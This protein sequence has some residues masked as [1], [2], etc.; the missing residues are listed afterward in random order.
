MEAGTTEN[1]FRF[2][3]E[4]G[5]KK[6]GSIWEGA[7]GQG[8]GSV[9]L[10]AGEQRARLSAN[11]T[12]PVVCLRTAYSTGTAQ[13][14]LSQKLR[15]SLFRNLWLSFTVHLL[16]ASPSSWG[17]FNSQVY[18]EAGDLILRLRKRKLREQGKI[19]SKTHDQ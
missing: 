11:G 8:R 18:P 16:C 19:H 10:E 2:L 12:E 1:S 9:C 7:W 3:W 15:K 14:L 13:E 4:W 5:A 6:Q 17:S